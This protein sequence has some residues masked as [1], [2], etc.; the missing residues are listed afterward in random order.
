[1]A[2]VQH[3]TGD[4]IPPVEDARRWPV[5][6]LEATISQRAGSNALTDAF[7]RV[8]RLFGGV[9]FHDRVSLTNEPGF[10]DDHAVIGRTWYAVEFKP[11]G[12]HPT[13]EQ[14]QWLQALEGVERIVTGCVR[15]KDWEGFLR[16]V[17]ELKAY[18]DAHP[19]PPREE[20]TAE[21][22]RLAPPA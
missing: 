17:H 9:Y 15:P 16:T 20:P 19:A 22:G 5:H 10:P 14:E 2:L 13:P 12:R 7:R 1:V 18:D 3:R 8:V 11:N 21:P 6:E 4:P